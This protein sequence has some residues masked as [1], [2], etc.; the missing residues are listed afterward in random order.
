MKRLLAIATAFILATAALW[1]YQTTKETPPVPGEQ[2]P[3]T[4]PSGL[5]HSPPHDAPYVVVLGIAQ[6]AGYPQAGCQKACCVPAWN[7]FRKRRHPTCVAVVDPVRK[8][9]WLFDC[10]PAFPDQLRMLD[11]IAPPEGHGVNGILLTHGHIGHYTGLIHLGREVMGLKDIPVHAM[12][13]MTELIRGHAPWNLL[14]R[15]GH[16]TLK[17]LADGQPVR[18]NQRIAVTPMVVPH[19]G[20]LS[21]TVAF[22]IEG[23]RRAVLYLPDIDKWEQWSTRIEDVIKTVDVAYLDGTFYA[24]GE[25]PG[26]DMSVIPHPFIEESIRRFANLSEQ[27]RGKVRFLH[28]NHTNPALHDDGEA[29]KGIRRAGHNVAREGEWEPL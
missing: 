29:V 4:Q 28:L 22:R 18:L 23:P 14:V 25:I 5:N 11:E 16:V 13:R 2:N 1:Y 6:D 20:E 9:R 21:E 27:E 7:D 8:E 15:Q 24:N 17:P 19:R 12:P 26:R 10:T 3:P